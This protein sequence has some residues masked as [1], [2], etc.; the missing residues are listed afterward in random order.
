[1][2]EEEMGFFEKRDE[3]RRMES[4]MLQKRRDIRSFGRNLRRSLRAGSTEAADFIARTGFD[5]TYATGNPNTDTERKR[6]AQAVD[7]QIKKYGYTRSPVNG[8]QAAKGDEK[9]QDPDAAK[10]ASDDEA[11][12]TTGSSQAAPTQNQTESKRKQAQDL[13]NMYLDQGEKDADT[14]VE[15]ATDLGGDED[16]FYSA[17]ERERERRS[18]PD[19]AKQIVDQLVDLAEK[20]N[21]ATK[22]EVEDLV[23][24][25]EAIGGDAASLRK[26]AAE[27]YKT[28]QKAKQEAEQKAEATR[29]S[30]Q[31]IESKR[32]EIAANN[33]AAGINNDAS[34]LSDE[35]ISGLLDKRKDREER[36][37]RAEELEEVLYGEERAQEILM[38]RERAAE[39]R[40]DASASLARSEERER[41]FDESEQLLEEKYKKRQIEREANYIAQ[42]VA[43]KRL[44]NERLGYLDRDF[45]SYTTDR[46][47]AFDPRLSPDERAKL[48][49]PT[50]EE[51]K[52]KNKYYIELLVYQKIK[53]Y[54]K[55]FYQAVEEVSDVTTIATP[56]TRGR[57]K[58]TDVEAS[59]KK[60]DKQYVT[61]ANKFNEVVESL[62]ISKGGR[63]SIRQ[64]MEREKFIESFAS[65]DIDAS[66]FIKDPEFKRMWDKR[67]AASTA[68]KNG[69]PAEDS[70]PKRKPDPFSGDPIAL[71]TN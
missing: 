39:M 52:G 16:S 3:R 32:Q 24:Q 65:R 58:K 69:A 9:G 4:A 63:S 42:S 45:Y 40:A 50:F 49:Q 18:K 61:Q 20:D 22:S 30:Q 5:T 51:I 57:R 25:A 62:N 6:A 12:T 26:A 28:K 11:E 41:L 7:D 46:L 70:S 38:A 2:A 71:S 64:R 66:R 59:D 34:N 53:D 1:M 19:K 33:A 8:G 36:E 15:Q 13:V 43:M 67:W 17:V 14:F 55:N 68:N 10:N 47:Q 27:A 44:S 21:G 60:Q 35:D 56:A 54:K 29:Y 37:R 48:V 31:E 23:K